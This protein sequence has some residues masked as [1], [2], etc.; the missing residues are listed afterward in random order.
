MAQDAD[1]AVALPAVIQRENHDFLDLSQF[2][3]ELQCQVLASNQIDA[4]GLQEHLFFVHAGAQGHV[5]QRADFQAADRALVATASNQT[6][7]AVK[8]KLAT[9]AA[10]Y[11]IVWLGV[12]GQKRCWLEQVEGYA[13]ILNNLA[14]TYP[15]VGV[16][17]DGWTMPCSPSEQSLREADKDREVMAKIT[18][19][20]NPNIRH[21]AAIGETSQHKLALGAAADFFICNF[22]TG[23][24]HISRFLRKPGFCHLSNASAFVSL[25]FSLHLHPNP[26]VYLLPKTFVTDEAGA[27]TMRHDTVSYS[28]KPA[29]FYDFIASRLA[30]VLVN[31]PPMKTRLFI[32]PSFSVNASLRFSLKQATLGN[33]LQLPPNGIDRLADVS[34]D[35]LLGNLIYG[36]FSFGCHSRLSVPADYFVWLREPLQRTHSHALQL[37]RANG[38]QDKALVDVCQAGHKALDNYL[39]RLLSGR[40]NSPFGQC[41]EAMLERAKANLCTF[42]FIGI[43]GRFQDSCDLL[44]Y[45]TG[46]VRSLFEADNKAFT[47]S[48]NGLSVADKALLVGLNFYDLLLYEFSLAEFDLR[49]GSVSA[50]IA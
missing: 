30:T 42:A 19:L 46:W 12:E 47:N 26:H 7:V 28:I 5:R 44:C 50:S 21:I 37:A 2:F 34:A 6:N 9:V 10:C 23:S 11:P 35:F 27:E 3:S 4:L 1:L 16:I 22:A 29:A 43:D 41:N 13:H 48:D 49:L 8:N 25:K 24:L 15:N 39:T 38:H 31:D 40:M 36:T 32:E 20:L 33:L 45:L 18:A 17:F 14:Q